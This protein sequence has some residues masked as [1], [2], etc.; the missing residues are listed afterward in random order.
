MDGDR[1]YGRVRRGGWSRPFPSSGWPCKSGDLLISKPKWTTI[2][3][4][5]PKRIDRV[6]FWKKQG[7]FVDDFFFKKKLPWR[8]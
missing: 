8:V 6:N 3:V 5:V 7:K 1:G 2:L 4:C